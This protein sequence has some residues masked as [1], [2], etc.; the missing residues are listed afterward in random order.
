M[1]LHDEVLILEGA[2]R[3]TAF[4]WC[5]RHRQVSMCLYLCVFGKELLILFI[6][7]IPEGLVFGKEQLLVSKDISIGDGCPIPPTFADAL[8][9]RRC[10]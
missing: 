5:R 10:E 4:H 1:R 9:E 8:A 2:G 6:K 7:I 3:E